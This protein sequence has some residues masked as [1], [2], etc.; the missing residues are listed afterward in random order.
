MISKEIKGVFISEPVVVRAFQWK[1]DMKSEDFPPWFRKMRLEGNASVTIASTTMT[2][3]KEENVLIG[4]KTVDSSRKNRIYLSN[5]RGDYYGLPED[6]IVS[7]EYGHI[8]VVS[9]K[10]FKERYNTI[11][12]NQGD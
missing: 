3:E 11:N 10:T 12:Y 5:K 2:I 1:I 7:D 6:W 4:N 8:F 9:Q